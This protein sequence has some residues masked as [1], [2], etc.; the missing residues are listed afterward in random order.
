MRLPIRATRTV[1]I[2]DLALA[3]GAVTVIGV[4]VWVFVLGG[5]SGESESIASQP[6]ASEADGL[7]NLLGNRLN[8]DAIRG[9]DYFSPEER[10][11]FLNKCTGQSTSLASPPPSPATLLSDEP[12]PA[13]QIVPASIQLSP[14][15]RTAQEPEEPAR[16]STPA[17]PTRTPAPVE[18]FPAPT[19][20]A[21]PPSVSRQ[22]LV[23][24]AHYFY[25]RYMYGGYGPWTAP[26]CQPGNTDC[27]G[28]CSCIVDAMLYNF[29]LEQIATQG[30]AATENYL[31]ADIQSCITRYQPAP[32][33]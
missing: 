13:P 6:P 12:T 23:D 14:S 32:L 25:C 15:Q 7:S 11:W 27:G 2:L 10:T 19:P 28:E 24:Y 30:P 1:R 26:I 9:T 8:C 5:L 22:D 17:S 18:P 29:T 31:A 4:A 33:Q 21:Q 20:Q 16:L 3:I